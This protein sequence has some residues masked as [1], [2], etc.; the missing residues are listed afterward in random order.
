MDSV[1]FSPSISRP[2][3][4][5]YKFKGLIIAMSSRNYSYEKQEQMGEWLSNWKRSTLASLSLLRRMPS[6]GSPVVHLPPPSEGQPPGSS[7]YKPSK[8][9]KGTGPLIQSIYLSQW[10]I[11]WKSKHKVT[12]CPGSSTFSWLEL[13]TVDSAVLGEGIFKHMLF[14]WKGR[15]VHFGMFLMQVCS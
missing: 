5:C 8:M 1:K 4:M 7:T 10:S 12:Q 14:D 2:S 11:L 13:F 3:G 6:W 9:E 15:Q